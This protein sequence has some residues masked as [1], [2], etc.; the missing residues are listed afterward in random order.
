MMWGSI[1]F[2]KTAD[3]DKSSCSIRWS[4]RW[5]CNWSATGYSFLILHLLLHSI[6]F[7]CLLPGLD[8]FV[9]TAV[10][11]SSLKTTRTLPQERTGLGPP[12]GATWALHSGNRRDFVNTAA[13]FSISS[14]FLAAFSWLCLIILT[15]SNWK[16]NYGCR[17]AQITVIKN[18]K[19]T[20]L[21]WVH[22]M[23]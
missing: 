3:S 23:I 17:P 10:R 11:A 16:L 12:T 2:T 18:K 13:Q 9:T 20:E 6:C 21:M 15:A 1:C 19:R 7:H 5:V 4:T 14:C 8:S 22:I